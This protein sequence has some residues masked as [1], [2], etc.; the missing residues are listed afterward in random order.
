MTPTAGSDL[1]SGY[2]KIH[3]LDFTIAFDLYIFLSDRNSL[4]LFFCI[5]D[6]S[7]QIEQ[8]AF[9]SHLQD[10][11]AGSAGREFKVKPYVSTG[12]KDFHIVINHH[13]DGSVFR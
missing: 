3:I 9:S 1:E 11:E 12:F 6:R 5:A 10:V 7:L 2:F 13:S 4:L 8:Q